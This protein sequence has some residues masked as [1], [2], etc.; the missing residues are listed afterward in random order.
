MNLSYSCNIHWKMENENIV[1]S[2]K[3]PL[4]LC[5]NCFPTVLTTVVPPP[6]PPFFVHSCV[7]VA[8]YNTAIASY[9]YEHSK[10]T[11]FCMKTCLLARLA[12]RGS[13]IRE[14]IITS[15]S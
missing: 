10:H 1:Y 3:L 6:P 14:C 4:K 11:K 12:K 5:L 8:I 7:A 13:P 15:H 2:P 9:H